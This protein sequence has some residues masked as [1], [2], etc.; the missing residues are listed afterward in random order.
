MN[1]TNETVGKRFVKLAKGARNAGLWLL[2]V[3]CYI[4]ILVLIGVVLWKGA[5]T[6]KI[7]TGD[8][9][10]FGISATTA[11]NWMLFAFSA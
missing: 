1:E 6:G 4:G 11:V 10:Y 8:A 2:G 9:L 3:G 5:V 7:S